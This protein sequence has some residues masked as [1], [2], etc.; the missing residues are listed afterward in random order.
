MRAG[1]YPGS[2]PVQPDKAI[3]GDDAAVDS[4]TGNVCEDFSTASADNVIGPERPYPRIHRYAAA[5]KIVPVKIEYIFLFAERL[6]IGQR[7]GEH[8]VL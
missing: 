7:I 2:L 8:R 1:P 4:R 6:E 3:A 5:I